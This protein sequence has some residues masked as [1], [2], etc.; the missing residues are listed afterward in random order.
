MTDDWTS[1]PRF[2]HFWL[3]YQHGQQWY[4]QHQIAYWKAQ[5]LAASYENE[6]LH[7]LLQNVCEC[8]GKLSSLPQPPSHS[9]KVDETSVVE[10]EDEDSYEME[11]S[12]DML[13]FFAKSMKHKKELKQLE[14]QCQ[15]SY[16]NVDDIPLEARVV[17][18]YGLKTPDLRKDEEKTNTYQKLYG[19]KADIINAMETAMQLTFHRNCDLKHPKLWPNMPL[20]M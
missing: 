2:Q 9:D 10:D 12:E 19:K 17:D 11:I 1:D 15:V 18:I 16:V 4:Q 14:D 8:K 13:E 3:N 5:A 6:Q 20:K 7:S